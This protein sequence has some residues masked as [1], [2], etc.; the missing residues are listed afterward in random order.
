M[1]VRIGIAARILGVCTKTL[2]RWEKRGMIVPY[3][4]A[5]KHRRYHKRALEQFKK[6][7]IYEPRKND[8]GAVAVYARVSSSRQK[9]DLTRQLAFLHDH[10]RV[11]CADKVHV[12]VYTDIASGLND[13][14]KGLLQLLRGA[15]RGQFAEVV[16]T[17]PDRLSRFGTRVIQEMLR[18]HGVTIHFLKK[19]EKTT[20]ADPRDRIVED[21][22]ALMRS[23]PGSCTGCGG[24]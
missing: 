19:T 20:A 17:Y 2:R 15:A 11:A 8:T 7:G 23:F 16:I 1:F 24:E 6:T 18:S 5:G 9:E 21:I 10:P 12:F 22:V 13:K 14:R 4:T 3:R